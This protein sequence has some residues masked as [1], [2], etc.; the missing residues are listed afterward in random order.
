MAGVWTVGSGLRTPVRRWRLVGRKLLIGPRC[1]RFTWPVLSSGC[2][3]VAYCQPLS[4]DVVRIK[5][6]GDSVEGLHGGLDLAGSAKLS[7]GE[8]ST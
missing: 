6:R 1:K 5:M 7:R 4:Q 2:V 3:L 8:D